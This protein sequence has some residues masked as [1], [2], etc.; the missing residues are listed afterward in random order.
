MKG[1]LSVVGFMLVIVL[2]VALRGPAQISPTT[3]AVSLS[4]G[5]TLNDEELAPLWLDRDIGTV[6]TA[7]SAS[8]LADGT[9]VVQGA[10]ADIWGQSD[11]FHFFY[12][13]LNGDGQISVRVDSLERSD[14]WA[15][16]G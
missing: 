7:G 6:K 11:G 4:T 10:G 14:N 5:E 12:L 15:K 8:I 3:D 16:A 13:S 9:Y 2:V 1:I